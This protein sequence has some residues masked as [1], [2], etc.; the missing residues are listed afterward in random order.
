[1]KQSKEF[2][3]YGRL[4]SD[5]CKVSRFLLPGVQLYIRLT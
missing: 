3:L 5:M 1:M 2:Q 4:H